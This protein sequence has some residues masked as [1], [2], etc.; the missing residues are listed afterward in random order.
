M[1]PT[2]RRL[3]AL[4][5]VITLVV[6]GSV[7]MVSDESDADDTIPETREID[8]YKADAETPTKITLRYYDDMPNVPYIG[9]CQLYR[10]YQDKDMTLT[11]EGGK[12]TLTNENGSAVVDLEEGIVY[13]DDYREFAKLSLGKAA[14]NPAFLKEVS[15]D[16]EG[17]TAATIRYSDYGVKAYYDDGD[18]YMPLS[19]AA[20]LFM[21]GTGFMIMYVPGNGGVATAA[22]H[23][24]NLLHAMQGQLITPAYRAGI[25]SLAESERT[26]DMAEFSYKNLCLY[27]DNFY[28]KVSSSVLGE[29]MRT[30]T[31]DEILTTSNDK[32]LIQ[33]KEWLNSTSYAQYVAGIIGLEAYLYDG[34]HTQ[35]DAVVRILNNKETHPEM[36]AAIETE[37]EKVQ[38]PE[39]PDRTQKTEGVSKARAETWSDAIVIGKNSRG[40]EDTYYSKGDTAVFSFNCFETDMEG[41]KEWTPGN[42]Y[43]DD[44]IS[45]FVTALD[46]AKA[47]P[48]I[49]NFVIDLSA[50]SGG[51]VAVVLYMLGVIT[52]DYVDMREMD[53][54]TG[55]I[56]IT[57]V[58]I[59]TNLD[60]E[61]NEADLGKKYDFDF[62]ML[63]T[64]LSFSS[65]NMLPVYAK[66]EG[67][68]IIGERSGGGI[69]SL[70]LGSTSDGFISSCSSYSAAAT[71]SGADVEA[72]AAP[73]KVLIDSSTTDYSVLYDIDEISRSM[74]DFYRKSDDDS[75]YDAVVIGAVAIAIIALA[76]L[77][78]FVARR[79]R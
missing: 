10:I 3:L 60:G 19:I 74:N 71:K 70:M 28:G 53:V 8:F 51:Y 5:A 12:Y 14:D 73:D 55:A 78:G 36:A 23:M 62:A 52:G 24:I 41:W 11:A 66:D 9:V 45:H 26:A 67:I 2:E 20:D 46:M 63:T 32:N 29:Q 40:E 7:I 17:S 6:C 31:L 57:R 43:P 13:S 54:Q 79:D 34:G 21:G 18:I 27:L 64:G 72:G 44:S 22:A 61:C 76:I 38:L 77:I 50:N 33:I 75:G 25:D 59:D 4:F 47:D 42:P 37:L 69:C 68:M 15:V 1:A 48:A 65:G 16:T 35:L 58:L 49:R 39:H 56:K 30:K